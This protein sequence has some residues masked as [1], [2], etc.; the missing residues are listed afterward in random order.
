MRVADYIIKRIADQGVKHVFTVTGRGIL[1]L[2]DALAKNQDVNP[3][4]VHNEQAG[5]YS[6]IAYSECN[7]NLGVQ[8]ISTGCAS[9]NAITG[10]MCAYQ[11]EVP[12]L[13]ISGQNTLRETTRYTKLNI[14][15]FGQQELDIVKIVE[16]ITKYAVM[17]EDPNKIGY[18]I[19]KCFSIAKS[20]RKGPVWL[21]VP[22]DIQNSIIDEHK[23]ERFYSSKSESCIYYDEI[24]KV[25]EV[26][27][28][29]Q[30]P[31]VIIGNQVRSLGAIPELKK[32]IEKFNIPVV[33]DNSAADILPFSNSRS[34]GIVSTLGGNRAANFAF[35]NSDFILALGSKL[36]SMTVG[37]DKEKIARAAKVCVVDID[38]YE[39]K[40]DTIKID[41]FIKANIKKFLKQI[42]SLT[43]NNLNFLNWTN[44]CRHWKSIFPK[45]PINRKGQSPLDMYDVLNSLSAYL[46]K[47]SIVVCDAGLEEL[48][49]P[50]TIEF[51]E[52]QRCIHPA[53]QGAMGFALPASVG[54]YLSLKKQVVAIIGDGSIMM[55]LQELQTIVHNKLP[56]KIIII[57]NNCYAVIRKRQKDLFRTRTVGT[58]YENGVSCPDFH[59]VAD[60]FGLRYFS[61]KNSLYFETF[62]DFLN[63][64]EA[65]ICEVFTTSEQ[66]FLHNSFARN[67]SGRFV[68][69]SLEDQSPFLD[70]DIFLREMI[71]DPID[72]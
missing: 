8:L 17:V 29:S 46:E 22:L 10:A 53:S 37:N 60:C 35:Q 25:L 18:E 52:N 15:S 39:I 24:D 16:P 20:G 70:R 48:L 65:A 44:K 13:F 51:N 19:D 66:T 5:A 50:S 36:N 49:T 21:D 40:K 14:R 55:N 9:T 68:R 12:V 6:A 56:V 26:L 23:L 47:D 59:K 28:N 30:R 11:D 57:N 72:Q 33:F 45:C 3:V 2:T 32:F 7:N 41:Y 64:P 63:S 54:A 27:N 69:R 42:N 34:I 71:I 58:D 38:E 31:I 1:Y 67:S 43:N 61:I 62:K 4:C